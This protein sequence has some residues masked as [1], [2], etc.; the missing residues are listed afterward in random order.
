[1]SSITI[2]SWGTGHRV[3]TGKEIEND[4]YRNEGGPVQSETKQSE[5]PNPCNLSMTRVS[6][7]HDLSGF[8]MSFAAVENFFA[9]GRGRSPFPSR[10][11]T[12]PPKAAPKGIVLFSGSCFFSLNMRW[13]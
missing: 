8:R 4:R 6:S 3:T 13:L 7:V 5:S 10:P 1:M 9:H 2:Q 12:T 11:Q